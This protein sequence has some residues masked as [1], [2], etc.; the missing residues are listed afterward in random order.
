MGRKRERQFNESS[1]K[2]RAP[3]HFD[4]KSS[5]S[6]S[7]A[8]KQP[9]QETKDSYKAPEGS[10]A[11]S[12]VNAIVPENTVDGVLTH[13]AGGGFL[14]NLGKI[15]KSAKKAKGISNFFTN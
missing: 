6:S 1:I 7:I 11:E 15:M 13:V 12:V 4:F 2:G 14:G 9:S 8:P 10:L 3:L 5:D